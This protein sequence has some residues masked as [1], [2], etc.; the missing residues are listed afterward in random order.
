MAGETLISILRRWIDLSQ[1]DIPIATAD[2][3]LKIRL[4]A[5]DQERF[6]QFAAKSNNGTLT[7]TEA[8]EYDALIAAVDLIALWKSKARIALARHHSAA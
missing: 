3:V 7:P 5:T 6:D 8:E 4:A 1:G 2:A